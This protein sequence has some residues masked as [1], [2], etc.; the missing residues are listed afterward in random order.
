MKKDRIRKKILLIFLILFFCLLFL[1]ILLLKTVENTQPVA[2]LNNNT[3][4]VEK[5]EPTKK[6]I[7]KKYNSKYI[8]E[9]VDYIQVVL[10]KGLFE[11]DGSSNQSYIE[12]LMTD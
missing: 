10:S 8:T 9:G 6:D 3:V 7:I 12:K 11:E 5:K 4:E 2:E 1:M